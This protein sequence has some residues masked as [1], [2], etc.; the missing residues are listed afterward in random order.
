MKA[1]AAFSALEWTMP[2]GRIKLICDQL[3]QVD[4]VLSSPSQSQ[5]MEK[6]G[7]PVVVV[8]ESTTSAELQSTTFDAPL[9]KGVAVGPTT[10]AYVIFTSGSTGMY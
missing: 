4:V 7:K 2:D 8:D 10:L 1:G 9:L 6:L 5:R 3:E